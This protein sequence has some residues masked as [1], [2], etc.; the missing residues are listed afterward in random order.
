MARS[1]LTSV[2]NDLIGDGGNVLWSLV[3]G[4]QLELEADLALL[5]GS[6]A[7]NF[8]YECEYIEADGADVAIGGAQGVLNVRYLNH[9]GDWDVLTEYSRGDCC[10]Y[11]GKGYMRVGSRG[12]GGQPPDIS[13]EWKEASVNLIF[14]QFLSSFS[15]DF[16]T[17]P[18]VD[19]PASAFFELRVSEQMTSVEAPNTNG[20]IPRAWKPIRGRIEILYSPTLVV[21]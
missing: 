13:G 8:V 11:S 4:E 6:P 12:A 3:Q 21:T 15:T 7:Q 17:Q 18:T 5:G 16:Q 19:T 2:S 20:L 10:E 1:K 9:R 14:I